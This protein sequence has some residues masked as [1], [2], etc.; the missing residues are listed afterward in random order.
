[1]PP[2]IVFALPRSRTAW[3]SRFLTYGEWA[4]GHDEIRHARSLDDVKAWFSQPNT[5]TAETAAAPWWR[6]VQKLRPDVRVVVVRRPPEEVIAS[7]ERVAPF[8]HEQLTKLIHS[9][10]RKLDQIEQRMSNVIS[11]AYDD[12][13]FESVCAGIFDHC[14]PYEHD[15]AWWAFWD[16]QN[17]QINLPAQIRYF[18]A[19][20]PQLMKLARQVKCLTLADFTRPFK[21]PDELTFQQDDFE[22][23]F[24][25]GQRLFA[26]HC[27]IVGQD[28]EAF[29]NKNIPEFRAR[30]ARGELQ[31]MTARSNGR[32]FGYLVTFIAPSL[33][34]VGE[35][36]A[37]HTTIYASPEFPRLGRQLLR[38]AQDA[39]KERGVGELALRAGV[40]ADGPRL[41]KLYER[42]GAE[43]QGQLYLL[44]L[45]D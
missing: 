37:V 22:T 17:V 8:N 25:D 9:L 27:S 7:L 24:R 26:E 30:E 6:T 34:T 38:A 15:H 40:V 11:V 4:C 10:D 12:L 14:L 20:Q 2:F 41:A 45:K 32:M 42:M 43:P 18:Q 33:E 39:L 16:K 1:M 3:L 19:Y 44:K 23:F 28:P 21:E 35:T 13:Q 36:V 5:G 29:L 31:I